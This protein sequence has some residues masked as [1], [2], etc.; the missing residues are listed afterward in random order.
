MKR[1]A[2]SAR[3]YAKDQR[4]PANLNISDLL[5]PKPVP[6]ASQDSA[7]VAVGFNTGI[8]VFRDLQ[9]FGD[10]GCAD[11]G[12]GNAGLMTALSY[13]GN[14]HA[15]MQSTCTY[16]FPV[17]GVTYIYAYLD[18]YSVN[19]LSDLS[20]WFNMDAAFECGDNRVF[21]K[22]KLAL[23]SNRWRLQGTC[24]DIVPDM[25][26]KSYSEYSKCFA[27]GRGN[28]HDTLRS[29]KTMDGQLMKCDQPTHAIN[30]FKVYRC[31]DKSKPKY[32]QFEFV[33]QPLQVAKKNSKAGG[34]LRTST[35]PTL[36]SDE[37]SP[38]FCIDYEHSP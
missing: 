28:M 7:K 24:V 29:A 6:A 37:P 4:A 35:R 10:F 31:N 26:L 15:A 8:R 13:N 17:Y 2:L 14:A 3:P 27:S 33:C 11:D 19:S 23:H 36:C 38:R 34:L 25:T 32:H 16:D 30:A 5:I 12:D 21:Q 20:A 22:L 18:T 1:R 9:K